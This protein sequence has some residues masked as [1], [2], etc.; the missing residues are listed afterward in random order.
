M[1][2]VFKTYIWKISN[3]EVN[4]RTFQGLDVA[5]E[6]ALTHFPDNEEVRDCIMNTTPT[7]IDDI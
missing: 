5:R 7:I 2:V 3:I 1:S 4:I 6:K